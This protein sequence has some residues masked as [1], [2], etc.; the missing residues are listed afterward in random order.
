MSRKNAVIT[1]RADDRTQTDPKSVPVDKPFTPNPPA[2]TT[3]KKEY[4]VFQT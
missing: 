2:G 3:V 4:Y 1:A